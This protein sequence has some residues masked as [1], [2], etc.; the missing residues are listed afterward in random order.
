MNSRRDVLA[1]AGELDLGAQVVELVAGVVAAAAEQHAVHTAAV[2]AD[3]A[4]GGRQRA[5]RV[6]ELD[7]A[8]ASGRRLPQHAEDGG[9]AHITPDNDPVGR[10]LARRRL[11]DQVGHGDHVIDVGGLDG[12][13]PVLRHLVGLDLHERDDAA[14]VLL[15]DL[16]HALQQRVAVVDHVV[17][18]QHGERHVA[19]VLG[20]AQDGVAQPE[21]GTLA[22]VVHVG[23]L[24]GG[25]DQGQPVLV[26]LG[27]QRLLELGVAVEIVFDRPLAAARDH[28]YVTQARGHRFF[29]NV[30][31][32]GGI[33]DG[34]DLLG[35]RLG[36]GQEPR[37]HARCGDDRLG[38]GILLHGASGVGCSIGHAE[39][40]N[41][42]AG[43]VIERHGP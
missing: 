42:T 24:A 41:R 3:A 37:S 9:I 36:H 7:L 31:N 25:A 16:D 17:A 10:R 2:R 40:P 23:E 34:Q 39:N 32:C 30:L 21:R 22:D 12:H 5:Q 14:A 33:D 6:G 19:H 15:P 1:V 13:A 20:G 4:V 11:L 28:Q 8:A 43:E 29:H 27:F 38:D 35:H 18:E 26:A